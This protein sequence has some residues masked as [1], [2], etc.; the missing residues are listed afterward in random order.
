ML[1]LNFI[2]ENSQKV[3]EACKNKNVSVSVDLILDLDKEKR[4]LMTEIEMLKAEQ[5]KIS[6]GGKDNN[7]LIVQAKEIKGKIKEMEPKLEKINAELKNLLFS[8]PNIPFDSVPVGKDESGNKVIRKWGRP[9]KF[10]FEPKDHVEIGEN[11]DLIDIETAGKVSGTRF[12][13]L[14]NQAAIIQY[15]LVQYVFSVLTS[16]KI[17]KKIAESVKRGFSSKLFSPM[18]VPVMIKPDVYTK[19]AR[20][21]PEDKD[22]RYYIP[23]DDV[24]LIGSAEHTLGPIHM[25]E[26]IPEASL[27]LRYVSFSNAFRREAGSYGKDTRGILRVHQ[28]DKIEMESFSKPEDSVLEQ[29]FFVAIQEYL[30]K[31]LGIPYQVVSICTGDMGKPDARQLDMECWIPS[32]KKYRETHTSDLMTDYQARRLNTRLKRKDGKVEF[33][34]MNDATAFAIGRI[35]IAILENYQQKDGSIKIPKVLQRYCGFKV[36][37]K[38]K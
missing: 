33:V 25:D 24:Y 12:A 29:D 28:F 19:M 4:R 8:L 3:K 13:Y 14:K 9:T 1:D 34:H 23:S 17:V 38:T 31:S 36:I 18:V 7:V 10:N 5:N 16:E 15:A 35:L 6:R 27:P 32:Q 20:L 22:E 11:L 30:I 2:R 26:I 37:K 21:S